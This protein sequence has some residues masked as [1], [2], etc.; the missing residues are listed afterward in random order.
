M[1][2]ALASARA[3]ARA[4]APGL[5][6]TSKRVVPNRAIASGHSSPM[7]LTRTAISANGRRGG[8]C[9]HRSEVALGCAVKPDLGFPDEG[10]PYPVC[11]K[12]GGGG[13]GV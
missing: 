3:C 4:L 2:G 6:S 13:Q 8:G 11:D 12:T 9:H 7:V 10:C 5:A 1:R